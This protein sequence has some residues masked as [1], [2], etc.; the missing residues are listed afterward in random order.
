MCYVVVLKV[1]LVF[2]SL[3]EGC[4]FSFYV[5]DKGETNPSKA[6]MIAEELHAVCMMCELL[7]LNGLDT[8]CG[9]CQ[10]STEV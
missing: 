9:S 2:Q 4:C 1:V 10:V 6:T 8:N 5:C 3:V 7:D